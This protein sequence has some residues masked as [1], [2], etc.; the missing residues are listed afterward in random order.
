MPGLDRQHATEHQL[1]AIVCA[2][3]ASLWL[4]GRA[5]TIGLAEEGLMI[6]PD[7]EVI[8]PGER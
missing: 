6:I 7:I 1:D 4:Q 3:T 8:S 2:L 5:R